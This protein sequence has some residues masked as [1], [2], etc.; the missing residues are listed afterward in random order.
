MGDK[1]SPIT[2]AAAKKSSGGGDTKQI[3]EEIEQ[4]PVE[5]GGETLSTIDEKLNYLLANKIAIDSLLKLIETNSDSSASYTSDFNGKILAIL[6]ATS[7]YATS[8]VLTVG[9]VTMTP[10]IV[11]A[12]AAG[13][14]NYTH[15]NYAIYVVDVEVGQ[16]LVSSVSTGSTSDQAFYGKFIG[17]YKMQ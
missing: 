9:G 14:P 12:N 6:G 13:T 4:T 11:S 10:L 17:F 7:R 15:S 5:A 8:F 16:Q 2:L 3:L 1:L